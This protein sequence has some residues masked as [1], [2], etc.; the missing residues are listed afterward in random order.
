MAP[1]RAALDVCERAF[2]VLANTMLIIML[3]INVMNIASRFLFEQGLAWVFPWTTV[4]FVWMSFLGFFVV[5]RRNKDITV[6]FL[7]AMAGPRIQ[8]IGRLVVNLAIVVLLAIIL[9]EAPAL[10]ER[11]VGTIQ[12]VGIERYWLSVPLFVSCA[13]IIVHFIV[14]SVDVVAGR[15]PPD[16]D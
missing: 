13:L 5:Y 8:M 15:P 7:M 12:M 14:D 2:L 16:D 9:I 4:L 10:L 6:E 11:Q 1:V 3:T